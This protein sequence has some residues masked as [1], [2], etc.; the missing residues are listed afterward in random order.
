MAR[1][2]ANAKA[3]PYADAVR[4]AERAS[5]AISYL[6]TAARMDNSGEI[7][8]LV[9]KYEYLAGMQETNEVQK[10]KSKNRGIQLLADSM[11]I[12][13]SDDTIN[14]NRLADYPAAMEFFYDFYTISFENFGSSS[15][16]KGLED[17]LLAIPNSNDDDVMNVL[18]KT[19]S[20][21][22]GLRYNKGELLSAK[23]YLDYGRDY[24]AGKTIHQSRNS[25]EY[26]NLMYLLTYVNMERCDLNSALS[27]IN[28]AL[29]FR[30]D[31][32]TSLYIRGSI[33]EEIGSRK[34]AIN[35]MDH[36]LTV[37]RRKMDAKDVDYDTL[38]VI[39]E[40]LLSMTYMAVDEKDFKSAEGLI[41][42][43]IDYYKILGDSGDTFY[44]QRLPSL[45][46]EKERF[47][48]IAY[49]Q[50]LPQNVI[51]TS[52]DTSNYS[53]GK[54][55]NISS[56]SSQ[57]NTDSYNRRNSSV[58]PPGPPSSMLSY[59][60]NK[61]SRDPSPRSFAASNIRAARSRVTHIRHPPHRKPPPM[62]RH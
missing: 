34:D 54:F 23:R 46:K 5:D 53:S 48:E 40:I 61:P 14:L 39:P 49:A 27:S 20:Y 44:K 22:G 52:P 59:Q 41:S 18:M 42:I 12:L 8:Y 57:G 33:Y 21:L 51:S 11:N 17:L 2:K 38:L 58:R 35:D 31:D 16:I 32:I 28:S 60:L 1:W 10:L 24:M 56:D 7:T 25:K 43:A 45:I 4:R 19:V 55:G 15:S 3:K 36:A 47:H 6:E 62:L 9:G 30:K 37:W 50:R 26:L 29:G 13:L